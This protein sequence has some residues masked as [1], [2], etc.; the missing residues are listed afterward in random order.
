MTAGAYLASRSRRA[1]GLET[2]PVGDRGAGVLTWAHGAAGSLTVRETSFRTVAEPA[3]NQLGTLF[4][5]PSQ[6]HVLEFFW[7]ESVCREKSD[8]EIDK[9]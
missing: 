2:V 4:R 9:H 3:L 6:C 1:R 5:G 7:E 8:G